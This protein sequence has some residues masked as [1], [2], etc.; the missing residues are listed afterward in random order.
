LILSLI[1]KTRPWPRFLLQ[2]YAPDTTQK[3][4][5]ALGYDLRLRARPPKASKP[6]ANSHVAAGTGT[7]LIVFADPV[8]VHPCHGYR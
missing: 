8:R 7:M 3:P 1:K 2:I 5:G 6:E 4:T